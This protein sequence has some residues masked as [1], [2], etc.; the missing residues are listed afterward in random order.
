M[1]ALY[2][3]SKDFLDYLEGWTKALPSLSINEVD[4]RPC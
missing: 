1:G 3:Q 4:S 2:E